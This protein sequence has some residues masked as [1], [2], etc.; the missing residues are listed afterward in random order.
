MII[1]GGWPVEWASSAG[2]LTCSSSGRADDASDAGASS[3]TITE[4]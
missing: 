1:G 4:D 2:V 3:V